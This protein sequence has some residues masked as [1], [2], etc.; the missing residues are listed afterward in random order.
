MKI[1]YSDLTTIISSK[2]REPLLT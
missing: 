2:Y 1:I